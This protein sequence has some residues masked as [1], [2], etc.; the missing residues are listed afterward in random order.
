MIYVNLDRDRVFWSLYCYFITFYRIDEVEMSISEVDIKAEGELEEGETLGNH[1]LADADSLA[2]SLQQASGSEADARIIQ[3]EGTDENDQNMVVASMLPMTSL[4]MEDPATY[5][6]LAQL[7]QAAIESA[8]MDESGNVILMS[9]EDIQKSMQEIQAAQQ[10]EQQQQQQHEAGVDLS[11]HDIQIAQ[12]HDE[13]ASLAVVQ[14]VVHAPTDG[15]EEFVQ[16][17]VNETGD[18]ISASTNLTGMETEVDL[19]VPT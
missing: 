3:I 15:T 7:T 13:A 14:D 5:V 2:A 17:Q 11:L 10:Q 12:Q 8:P 1:S 18:V 16:V 6:A 19:N 4:N 9:Y